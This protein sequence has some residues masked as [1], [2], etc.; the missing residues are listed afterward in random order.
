MTLLL[1]PLKPKHFLSTFESENSVHLTRA[2][3]A[4]L[5]WLPRT[6]GVMDSLA[7]G[8]RTQLG[9]M[10][11]FIHAASTGPVSRQLNEWT[12]LVDETRHV[13][14]TAESDCLE[15][16]QA[17]S[18]KGDIIVC[19]HYSPRFSDF[20]ITWSTA[21][22]LI[23]AINNKANL[24][25]FVPPALT[26]KRRIVEA[27]TLLEEIEKETPPF[28]LKAGTAYSTGGSIA[29]SVC[30]T[31]DSARNAAQSFL[32]IGDEQAV[33]II[34]AFYPFT[35]TWCANVGIYESGFKYFGAAQQILDDA[36]KQIGNINGGP[37]SAPDAVSD[38]C[39]QVAEN[40]YLAGY[41]GFAGMDMG[42]TENNEL[43][44]FDLNFRLNACT[45]QIFY[46]D[47]ACA[48]IGAAVSKNCSFNYAAPLAEIALKVEDAVKKG[49]FVP[50]SS[51]DNALYDP[52]GAGCA[53]RGIAIGE[54]GDK[55]S[56]VA[57]KIASL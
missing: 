26:P 28:V 12:A 35:R 27:G 14:F 43:Y 44:V 3:P 38:A 53:L 41:R 33:Y 16:A 48:R 49:V 50:L 29:V 32:N 57:E 25:K 30:R 22:E 42:L 54:D 55:A 7:N 23:S 47:S 8:P 36:R 18:R 10:G 11:R 19:Q 51:F 37:F 9:A 15:Q 39:L 40:A 52:S 13:Y 17:L 20:D 4:A 21:P 6:P 34:E 1:S 2:D 45:A 24:A 56:A 46:H 5:M 31:M